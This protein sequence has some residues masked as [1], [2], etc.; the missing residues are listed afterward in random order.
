[1]RP[2]RNCM[3]GDWLSSTWNVLYMTRV[4]CENGCPY[5]LHTLIFCWWDYSFFGDWWFGSKKSGDL[6]LLGVYTH[7]NL[8]WPMKQEPNACS[9]MAL[10]N[11]NGRSS[12]RGLCLVHYRTYMY[13]HVSLLLYDWWFLW[14]CQA[15]F[16]SK[17]PHLK[18]CTCK[19]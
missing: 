8:N 13:V 7:R 2:C 12:Q 19:Y 14:Y 10:V 3:I 15:W 16:A 4:Q 17:C 9:C 18:T 11:Q 1:M 6:A 5:S